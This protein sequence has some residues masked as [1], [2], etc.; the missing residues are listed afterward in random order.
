MSLGAQVSDENV[1][2]ARDGVGSELVK[3]I[4]EA[5]RRPSY[6]FVRGPRGTDGDGFPVPSLPSFGAGRGVSTKA[7]SDPIDAVAHVPALPGCRAAI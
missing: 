4:E 7:Q 3:A 1:R 6:C 5:G 2:R